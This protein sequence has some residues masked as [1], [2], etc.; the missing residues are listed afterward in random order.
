M[1]GVDFNRIANNVLMLTALVFTCNRWVREWLDG[2]I[3]GLRPL[4][5]VLHCHLYNPVVGI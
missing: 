5:M 2:W 1:V 4:N 3:N